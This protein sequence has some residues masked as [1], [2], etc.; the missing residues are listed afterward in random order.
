MDSGRLRP[1]GYLTSLGLG[2]PKDQLL[3]QKGTYTTAYGMALPD[4]RDY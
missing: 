1:G 2:L 4:E 3:L